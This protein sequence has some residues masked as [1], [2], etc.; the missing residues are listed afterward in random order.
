MSTNMQLSVCK[1]G[2]FNICMEPFENESR[3]FTKLISRFYVQHNLTNLL[4][5][6][7]ATFHK[8][9]RLFRTG[10]GSLLSWLRLYF[11]IRFSSA[12]LSSNQY[13]LWPIQSA[14]R[15]LA[16]FSVSTICSCQM[17]NTYLMSGISKT[18]ISILQQ[19]KIKPSQA[20]T[21]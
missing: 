9:A 16:A 4:Y 2:V 12:G 18:V 14:V 11:M 7:T 20:E 10:S 3:R 6:S 1:Q 19:V 17:I 8:V 21:L 15:P 13:R 5:G